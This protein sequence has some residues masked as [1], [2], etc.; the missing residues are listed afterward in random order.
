MTDV[1]LHL[2]AAG[3]L[4]LMLAAVHVFFPKRFCWREELA[5]LSTLNRQI[6]QVHVLF[7][8]LI[9]VLMGL[10]SIFYAD[11]LMQPDELARAVLVGLCTFWALR[12][13]VQWFVYDRSLWRGQPLNTAVHAVASGLWAY[14]GTVYGW[15]AWTTFK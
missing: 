9:L 13:V 14:L 5:R 12:L 7:I 10:L 2:K 8:V 4:L 1:T 15:A 11:A 6:F 3:I